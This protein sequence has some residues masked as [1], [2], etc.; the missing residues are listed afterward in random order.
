MYV[1]RYYEKIKKSL[2][3]EKEGDAMQLKT[4]TWLPKEKQI[5]E[6]KYFFFHENN[7]KYVVETY[8]HNFF[9]ILNLHN[10]EM[11][12]EMVYFVSN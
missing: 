10:R 6:E 5:T 2:T 12:K 3:N 11:R 4:N 8:N 1:F 7:F 9:S